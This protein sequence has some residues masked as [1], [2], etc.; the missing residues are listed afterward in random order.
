M[1]PSQLCKFTQ[2]F[3]AVINIAPKKDFLNAID[4]CFSF[5]QDSKKVTTKYKS[6]LV[7]PDDFRMLDLDEPKENTE[8][9]VPESVSGN[10]VTTNNSGGTVSGKNKKKQ[11]GGLRSIW[12]KVGM[13]E[14]CKEN[15]HRT[16]KKKWKTNISCLPVFK[17]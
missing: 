12:A 13:L 4:Y 1:N 8:S 15:N 9:K 7:P 2:I 10:S 16:A 6:G 11:K 3:R 5:L 14:K 17:T